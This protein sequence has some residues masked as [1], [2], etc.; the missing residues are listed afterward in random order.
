MNSRLPSV[1]I[2]FLKELWTRRGP[3]FTTSRRVT[4]LLKREFLKLSRYVEEDVATNACRQEKFRS[5]LH[6]DLKLSLDVHDFADFATLVNKAITVE[7]A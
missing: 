2:T 4:R 3:S 7:I 1:P 6:P 5:G